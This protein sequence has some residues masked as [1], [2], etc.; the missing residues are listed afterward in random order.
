MKADTVFQ[1]ASMTKPIAGVACLQAVERGLLQLDQ[2]AAE[3]IPQLAD[4]QVLE[5]IKR[6]RSRASPS[7][8]SRYVA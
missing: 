4:L 7:E 3:I 5:D 2:P 6:I 1:I 8:E